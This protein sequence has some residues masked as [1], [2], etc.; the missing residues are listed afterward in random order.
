MLRMEEPSGEFAPSGN[1]AEQNGTSGIYFRYN[2][3]AVG[4]T[5]CWNTT[6]GIY[7]EGGGHLINGN[8]AVHNPSGNLS[9]YDPC[10][11]TNN[12]VP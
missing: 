9:A 10:T 3:T 5:A 12:Y 4:N 1:T 8:T 2:S 7:N 6:Y 11:V